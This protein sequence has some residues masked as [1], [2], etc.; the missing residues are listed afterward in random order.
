[1]E[2]THRS[3]AWAMTTLAAILDQ[4]GGKAQLA[5]VPPR[6]YPSFRPSRLAQSKEKRSFADVIA[7]ELMMPTI[8]LFV[9]ELLSIMDYG[10]TKYCQEAEHQDKQARSYVLSISIHVIDP[11]SSQ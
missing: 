7:S 1:V 2:Q 6:H 9:H 5:A 4:G 8:Q 11:S 3:K 10:A